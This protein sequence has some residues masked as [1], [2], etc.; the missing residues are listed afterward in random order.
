VLSIFRS[1]NNSVLVQ[2][3]GSAGSTWVLQAS[4][5]MGVS[6]SWLPLATNVLGT[7]GLGYVSDTI[8]N[9]ER[10]YRGKLQ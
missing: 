9:H 1:T 7:N 6:A 2:M 8:T 4:T 5:N 3:S 10:F